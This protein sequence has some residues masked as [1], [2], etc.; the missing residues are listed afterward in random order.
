[1]SADSDFLK[2][3]FNSAI[4]SEAPGRIGIACSGGGDSLALLRLAVDYA[5][6]NGAELHC[7]TVDH[8]LRSGSDAEAEGVTL[9]CQGLGIPHEITRWT[10]WDGQGN[11]QDEAR[12]AR[13]G[14]IADF[15]QR[16]EL[17]LICLGHT[18]DDQAE[19]VLMQIAR[20]AGVDGLAAMAPKRDHL[21]VTWLRPLLQTRRKD[22]RGFLLEI[23]Q[24]WVDDPSNEDE[25]FDRIKARNILEALAPLGVSTEKLCTL[26]GNMADARHALNQQV[27][28]FAGD[29][30][31]VQ[32]GDVLLHRENLMRGHFETRRRLLRHALTWV[33]ASDYGPRQ[34]EIMNLFKAIKE[35]RTATLAGCLIA[36][37]NDRIRISREFSAVANLQ[38]A[39][40]EL[41][42][43]RWRLTP[44]ESDA[45]G[46]TIRA[47][48]EEALQL[49]PDWRE[50]GL[51]RASTIASPAAFRGDALLAAPL[52]GL[53]NGWSAENACGE[54]DFFN[55]LVSH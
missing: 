14:M 31:L 34:R 33:S 6:E 10:N 19:T 54:K 43:N 23:G 9:I 42:D 21:G 44:N 26:A 25:R 3:Q 28:H 53:N 35:E 32:E 24:E 45:T 37:E 18:S 7:I 2:F 30:A 36:I 8:G 27:W 4:A 48:G 22:L 49:C 46:V 11:L 13:Y 50:T 17:D 16:L 55:S 12:R 41:W 29:V 38:T 15:A 39:P 51:S 40:G 20:S 47:L 1:M 52:A 5:R